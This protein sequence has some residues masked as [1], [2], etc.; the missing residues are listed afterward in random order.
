MGEKPRRHLWAEFLRNVGALTSDNPVGL[1][2]LLQGSFTFLSN[3]TAKL[4]LSVGEND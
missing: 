1:H 4:P 3:F 2:C